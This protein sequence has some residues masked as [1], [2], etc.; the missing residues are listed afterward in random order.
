MRGNPGRT[1]QQT[2]LKIKPKLD[3]PILQEM[4]SKIKRRNCQQQW[5]WKQNYLNE[6]WPP[7]NNSE[8]NHQRIIRELSGNCQ[9]IVRELS[10]NGPRIIRELSENYQRNIRELSEKPSIN[11]GGHLEIFQ[12]TWK[13]SMPPWKLSRP[14]GN[15]QGHLETFQTTVE[16]FYLESFCHL[17]SLQNHVPL[18]MT[19]LMQIYLASQ[20]ALEVMFSLTDWVSDG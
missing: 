12:A 14:P 16:I 15:F 2:S 4:T 6:L 7:S 8:K 18:E 1:H 9:G 20:D 19:I 13:L 5:S 11:F 17:R 10:E 3:Q